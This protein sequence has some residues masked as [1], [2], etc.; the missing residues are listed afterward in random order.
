MEPRPAQ[1]TAAEQSHS[2]EGWSGYIRLGCMATNVV[3][4]CRRDD[5]FKGSRLLP[6]GECAE[7]CASKAGLHETWMDFLYR[8]MTPEA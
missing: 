3:T 5:L 8:D 4:P 7:R 1:I 6:R 2:P